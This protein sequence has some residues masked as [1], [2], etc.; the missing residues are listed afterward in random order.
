MRAISLKRLVLL[1][2]LPDAEKQLN[3]FKTIQ[4]KKAGFITC[5]FLCS[6]ICFAQKDW[7][8]DS[9]LFQSYSLAL[10]LQIEKS[11]STLSEIKTP[12]Q[13]YV[14][15][16]TDALELL[17]TE[18]EARF[19]KCEDVYESRLEQVEEIKVQTAGSLFATAELR[20]Q[21]AFIYLKFGHEL[22]AAWNVRQA[23]LTVQECKKRFPEFVPIKKTSGLLEMMLGSVPEKY[24]WII[25]LLNME[26]SVETGIKEL[27]VI[28]NQSTTLKLETTLL[29]YLFQSFT[30]QHTDVAMVGFDETIKSHPDNQL[31]LFLGASVAIKNSQGEKAL[32]YLKKIDDSAGAISIWYSNYQLGEVHLHKGDYESSIL[33]YQKFL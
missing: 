25:S 26:G 16:L 3:K 10:T 15:S 24:Q 8:T 22:D 32:V 9:Q 19:E 6:T 20:L 5:L 17:L 28:R 13:I 31:A 11:R 18:D 1:L 27:E 29:Y 7:L 12:E 33:S 4:L 30:L 2:L 14:A 21:W 23:Y